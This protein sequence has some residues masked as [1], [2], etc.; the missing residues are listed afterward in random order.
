MGE[1]GWELIVDESLEG[2]RGFGL[3]LGAVSRVS[4][5]DEARTLLTEE[6]R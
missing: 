1:S 6:G 2:Q 4:T 5:D 3:W